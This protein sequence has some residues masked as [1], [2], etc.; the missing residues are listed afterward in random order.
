MR[1]LHA[2]CTTTGQPLVLSPQGSFGARGHD[3]N[4]DCLR[5]PLGCAFK[6]MLCV[7]LRVH[8]ELLNMPA[9][10]GADVEKAPLVPALMQVLLPLPSGASEA[11]VGAYPPPHLTLSRATMMQWVNAR[12]VS[13]SAR[14]VAAARLFQRVVETHSLAIHAQRAQ[15]VLQERFKLGDAR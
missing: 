14:H 12:G 9:A 13:F 10:V 11:S 6:S 1:G 8:R 5:R 2:L 7:P 15:E 4:L 3:K